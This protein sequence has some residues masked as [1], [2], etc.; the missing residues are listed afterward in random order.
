MRNIPEM[1]DPNSAWNG[2]SVFGGIL[3]GIA[4][5]SGFLVGLWKGGSSVGKLHGENTA[6]I[7]GLEDRVIH[8]ERRHDLNDDRTRSIEIRLGTLP[9]RDEIGRCCKSSGIVGPGLSVALSEIKP[10]HINHQ[11]L[12]GAFL[13][14]FVEFGE[15]RAGFTDVA[16]AMIAATTTCYTQRLARS[17]QLRGER[18]AFG[19]KRNG[20]RTDKSVGASGLR[21]SVAKAFGVVSF[22][23][24]HIAFPRCGDESRGGIAE[25]GDEGGV[26]AL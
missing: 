11:P 18:I 20:L 8:L 12:M 1:A 21:G 6:K 22:G 3:S 26:A 17:I 7:E 4:A 19:E 15:N 14:S 23:L 9:T 16:D 10:R 25:G 13:C 2:L 24:E 5:L